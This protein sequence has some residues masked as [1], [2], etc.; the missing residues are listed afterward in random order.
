MIHRFKLAN[1]PPIVLWKCLI[2]V[3]MARIQDYCELLTRVS[4]NLLNREY[5]LY[6]YVAFAL[7][8]ATVVLANASKLLAMA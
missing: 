8:V 1:P 5:T 2:V 7:S 4:L 3:L 6:F